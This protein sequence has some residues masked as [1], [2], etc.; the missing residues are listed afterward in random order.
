MWMCKC[1]TGTDDALEMWFWHHFSFLSSKTC[2]KVK[3]KREPPATKFFTYLNSPMVIT[4]KTADY[5]LFH[6]STRG[7]RNDGAKCC[8]N[9]QKCTR[10]K[11]NQTKETT[12]HSLCIY[13]F[14]VSHLY[15]GRSRK[16]IAW[17]LEM[18][19]IFCILA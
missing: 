13:L 9:Q 15:Y 18:L 1:E 8:D 12:N 7:N 16:C 11:W 5:N 3:N 14:F 6:L 19:I 17:A 10:V 4:E 2:R